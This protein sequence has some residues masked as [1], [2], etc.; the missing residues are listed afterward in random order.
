MTASVGTVTRH[1]ATCPAAVAVSALLQVCLPF[2][3]HLS[4][5]SFQLAAAYLD[6]RGSGVSTPLALAPSCLTAR[7]KNKQWLLVTLLEVKN[8][9]HAKL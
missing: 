7:A 5:W 6:V 8:Q 3:Q 1:S 2:V 4:Q 9:S